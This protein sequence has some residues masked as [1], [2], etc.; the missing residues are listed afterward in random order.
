MFVNI[1]TH[2][3]IYIQRK[4]PTHMGGGG[5]KERERDK[6]SERDTETLKLFDK[7]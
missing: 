6:E 5:D 4:I 1:H 2:I 7:A 3:C